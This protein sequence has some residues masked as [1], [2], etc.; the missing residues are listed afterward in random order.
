MTQ[1]ECAA[2]PS[3]LWVRLVLVKQ[4]G[5]LPSLIAADLYFWLDEKGKPL[6]WTTYHTWADWFGVSVDTVKRAQAAIGL[7]FTVKRTR[8]TVS[9]KS[10]LGANSYQLNQLEANRVNQRKNKRLTEIY[11]DPV[12]VFPIEFIKLAKDHGIGQRVPEFAW[13]LC[14]IGWLVHESEKHTGIKRRA[15][16]KNLSWLSDHCQTS[17][18]T[19]ERFIEQS[20][21]AGLLVLTSDKRE[22]MIPGDADSLMI[23]PFRSIEAS[24]AAGLTNCAEAGEYYQQEWAEDELYKNGM[25]YP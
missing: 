8:R 16:V 6:R 7:L 12:Q 25:A 2:M 20:D 15:A 4:H 24:R 13:F 5:V 14:R 19:L 18:R 21:R 10:V 22:L 23:Q 11:T 3:M 1:A 9:G 17:V